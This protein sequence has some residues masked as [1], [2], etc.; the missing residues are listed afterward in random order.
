MPNE[1]VDAH[2]ITLSATKVTNVRI[3]KSYRALT[4]CVVAK[5]SFQSN[6][7]LKCIKKTLLVA[8]R[9]VTVLPVV[10]SGKI[11]QHEQ[12]HRSGFPDLA[13]NHGGFL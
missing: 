1:A 4:R 12:Y 11:I 6:Y 13:R 10:S 9:N 8:R 3:W 2:G 5:G 7:W